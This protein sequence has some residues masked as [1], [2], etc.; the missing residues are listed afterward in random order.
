MS[1]LTNQNQAEHLVINVINSVLKSIKIMCVMIS[2]YKYFLNCS[3]MNFCLGCCLC[4]QS[5][6]EL[7]SARV[8]QHR[9]VNNIMEI[10]QFQY[11]KIMELVLN[12]NL[13]LHSNVAFDQRHERGAQRVLTEFG[14][15][16]AGVDVL[17]YGLSDST[18]HFFHE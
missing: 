1:R 14:P 5:V 3:L 4:R 18:T 8:F 10:I 12:K 11:L 17:Y 7:M 16:F 2:C 15:L 9:T 6:T 13:H